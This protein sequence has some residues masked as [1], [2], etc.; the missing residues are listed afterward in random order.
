M[1]P[2]IAYSSALDWLQTTIEKLELCQMTIA[3]YEE[4]C[5]K[6]NKKDPPGKP[7]DCIN[8]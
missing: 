4:A 3:L 6:D 7:S 2:Y 5:Y 1:F 8:K